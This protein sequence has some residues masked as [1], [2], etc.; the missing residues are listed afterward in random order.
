MDGLCSLSLR[1]QWR[2]FVV[3][4]QRS[5]RHLASI[6]AAVAAD[7]APIID[8]PVICEF[9]TRLADG[10]SSVE[11]LAGIVDL[12][13]HEY[14]L[15]CTRELPT[16]LD[17]LAN[18]NVS[19]NAIVGPALRGNTRWDLTYSGRLSGRVSPVQFV[20]RLPVRNFSL[21]ENQLVRW[22]VADLSLAV[23]SIEARLGSS[24]VPAS[25]RVIRD[26][27]TEATKHP[28]FK[29]V[30]PPRVLD[31][32]MQTS[33]LRRRLPAYRTAATLAQRR[34]GFTSRDR[35][36]R[37]KHI[38]TLLSANWLSPVSDDD[39]FE[40]YVLTF[41]L[42]LLQHECGFGLPVQFG[43]NA[44]GRTHIARFEKGESSVHVFFDQ[45]PTKF[46]EAR[47]VQLELLDAHEGVRPVPRRPD[48]VVVHNSG[49]V[50]RVLFVEVKR[51]T[52]GSYV[53][54]SIYK[55][56]GYLTDFADLWSSSAANPKVALIVPEN[57][58][59]KTSKNVH[60]IEVVLVSS[61]DRKALA[62]AIQAALLD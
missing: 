51:S 26:A 14:G 38:V 3:S 50:R 17:S 60:D 53:S 32:H 56:F 9:L 25:L 55:A 2:D 23:S 58:S 33:A 16:L 18:D 54:D 52:D 28:W 1:Q 8:D 7:I 42:D 6:G 46:L 49:S 5:G 34:S 59:L 27:C 48:I 30:V 43:L 36:V 47:S 24:S 44:A 20:T 45:S 15:F 57:V 41:V 35:I 31:V 10:P 22:L 62:G 12:L 11:F 40:L 19:T 37:W 39:L 29:D 13:G 21:P 4:P 61:M